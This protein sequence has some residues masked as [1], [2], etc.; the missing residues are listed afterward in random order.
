MEENIYKEIASA[1][2]SGAI[3][4]VKK[5]SNLAPRIVLLS[6]VTLYSTNIAIYE[7]NKNILN[8]R[9]S[10]LGAISAKYNFVHSKVF[11]EISGVGYNDCEN[12]LNILKTT[13]YLQLSINN[14]PVVSKN[15]TAEFCEH[16]TDNDLVW[17]S[18]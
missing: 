1:S 5:I 16:N 10:N 11:Y 7:H 15:D 12:G 2:I 3:F 8:T 4:L 17:K 9:F 14:K 6:L 13:N 18:I